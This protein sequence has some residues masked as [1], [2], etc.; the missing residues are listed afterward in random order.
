MASPAAASRGP[1]RGRR[2]AAALGL[3]ALGW[4]LYD[5]ANTIFSYAVVTRYFNEWIIIEQGRPDVYVG[6]M[7]LAVSV[8]L[9]VSLPFV[10]AL[11]DASGRRMPFLAG[12]TVACVAATALLGLVEG[13]AAALV[14]G[15]VAIFFYNSA[16]AHYDPLL[17]AVAPPERRG[18][19]SGLGVGTG[20]V[21]VLLALLV[22][23]Q[24]VPEGDNQRAFLPTAALFLLLSVPCFLWVRDRH[25]RPP[26]DVRAPTPSP[27]SIVEELVTSVR[28]ARSER[29]GRLLVARFFYVD[30]IATVIAYMTVYARRTGEFAGAEVE[31]LLA[32]S[33]VFAV[34]GGVAAG[35]LV[36]R[37][38]PKR[39]LTGTLVLVTAT[40]LATGLSGWGPLLWVAGPAVGI[41]LGAVWTSDRVFLIRL[42]SEERRGE[43]FGL[44]A[45]IGKASSGIGPLVLWGGAI[46]LLTEVTGLLDPFGASRVALCLLSASALLGLAILRPLSD[47]ET[48]VPP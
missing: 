19:V 31:L 9:V 16:L 43:A 45:L 5:L 15:G 8:A 46:Y 48:A 24:L 41:G 4:V 38:G 20:Y 10:G 26:G 36:E 12:F 28:R 37:V 34:L 42:C 3:P 33:V 40:L 35:A 47:A 17:T 1:V 39:V 23:G 29:H 22:L 13:V 11:A 44:Y 14:V 2:A 32:S 27:K 25:V 18:L 30:A 6:L 21:G 7:S